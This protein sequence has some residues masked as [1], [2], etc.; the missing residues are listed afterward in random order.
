MKEILVGHADDKV[1]LT[2]CT[3]VICPDEGAVAGVDVRGAAPGTRETDLLNPVMMVEKVHAILLSGGSAYGLAAAD[4]VMSYLEE[5]GIGFDVGPTY[6]PI[7]PSAVIFDL[8]IGD[9]KVRPDREMGYL[10]CMN[11]EEWNSESLHEGCIGAGMGATVGKIKGI[12]WATKSG[13]GI[14]HLNLGELCVSALVVVNA[15]GDVYDPKTGK[16]IA[17][18]RDES[19]FGDTT[20]ILRANHEKVMQFTNTTIGVVMTNAALDK[21]GATK[22]AQVSHQGLVRTIRPIHTQFDGDT[23]FALSYGQVKADPILLGMLAADAV[24]QAVIR[25]VETSVG[26]G[27]VPA[28]CDIK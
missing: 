3:V 4:G 26:K 11:A 24:S 23:L 25:A 8:T 6:V 14:A 13:L 2:G 15:L 9:H 19:G 20:E 5:K 28:M 18:V 17:G 21:A 27:G 22:L 1:G 16:V 12:E 7:V 10:A